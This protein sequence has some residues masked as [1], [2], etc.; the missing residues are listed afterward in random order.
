MNIK[1]FY[2]SIAIVAVLMG[3]FLFVNCSGGGSGSSG[4]GSSGS[5]IGNNGGSSNP[6]PGEPEMMFVQG[7]TFTMGCT[8]EQGNDCYNDEKPPH[9]VTL[10]NFSIGKYPV[11][12]KQWVAVMGSYPS[13]FGGDNLPVEGVSWHD[14]QEFIRKLNATTG[15]KYR[16]PTEAE[17]EYAARGGNKSK[18]FKYSGSNILDDVAWTWENSG[19]KTHP[20]GR[21]APNELGIYDMSGNV[22]EWCNDRY[23]N[24]Y[25]NSAKTNPTGATTGSL[26][27]LRGGSWDSWDYYANGCRVSDRGSAAPGDRSDYIG[28]RLASVP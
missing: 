15:K 7:G 22:R 10:S 9:Q 24:N 17:W 5:G 25:S 12:Q 2:S 1:S 20:V 8:A 26:R 13:Y 14:V 11:T 6:H 3:V 16:L 27:V 19:H 4:S 21:K 23:G 18:G 28:F